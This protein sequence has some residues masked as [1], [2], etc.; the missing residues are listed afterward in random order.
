MLGNKLIDQ[1]GLKKIYH[2]KDSIV[3]QYTG[4]KDKNGVEIYEGDIVNLDLNNYGIKNAI[5]KWH[6]EC[7]SWVFDNPK[8]NASTNNP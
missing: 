2:L 5:V 3:E 1:V 8:Q 4:L 7:A 6:K